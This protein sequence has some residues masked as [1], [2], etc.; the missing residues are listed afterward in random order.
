MIDFR[1]VMINQIMP[2][3]SRHLSF[4]TSILLEDSPTSFSLRSFHYVPIGG[5]VSTP[6][7]TGF[8]VASENLKYSTFPQHSAAVAEIKNMEE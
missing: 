1:K 4:C 2:T 3:T 7:D 5:P 8:E 6:S